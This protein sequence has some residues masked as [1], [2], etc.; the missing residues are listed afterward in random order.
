MNNNPV[1]LIDQPPIS[2]LFPLNIGTINSVT[3][4]RPQSDEPLPNYTHPHGNLWLGDAIKWLRTIESESVDLVFADPP[5]NIKK[6]EWDTFESQQHYI[7][8]SLQ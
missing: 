8:W 2:S 6:A 5:Y 4:D 7:D 3:A 1:S